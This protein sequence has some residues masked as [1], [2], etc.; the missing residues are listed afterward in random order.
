ME[1]L[2][3]VIALI[4]NASLQ[5]NI[6]IPKVSY[7]HDL[8]VDNPA[9]TAYFNAH[10]NEI[11]FHKKWVETAD[12][13][14][15]LLSAYIQIRYA[16][17]QHSIDYDLNEPIETLNTWYKEKTTHREPIIVFEDEIDL[18]YISQSF[19]IDA[20]AYGH[21]MLLEHHDTLSVI[22]NEIKTRVL[23]RV[24]VLKARENQITA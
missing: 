14:E 3:S 20:V 23:E 2:K 18:S 19:V 24:A 21:L 12:P 16:Y 22:P 15:V 1:K 17:Q 5:L 7:A 13:L 8:S 6:P 9:E 11:Y 4:E 10:K